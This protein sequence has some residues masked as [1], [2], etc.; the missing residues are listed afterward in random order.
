MSLYEYNG[1]YR[2]HIYTHR[3][4]V[5][6][7]LAGFKGV[8]HCDAA[9]T[10][11]GI[12]EQE[13]VTLSYCHAHGRRKFEEIEKART[14]GKKKVNPGLAATVL[15]EVYRPLYA[16][17]KKMTEQGLSAPD[18]QS[19]R[20]TYSRPILET[21]QSWLIEHEQLTLPHSPIGKAIR[22]AL[23]HW[24]GLVV[25]L[26]DGRVEI[27]NNATERDS[28]P[29]VMWRKNFLFAW[30]QAGADSLGVHFS[31]ILTAKHHGL[32]P[33]QYYEAIFNRLP[34]CRSI[35]DYEA[36]LP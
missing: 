34:L 26:S 8:L 31:L 27:D 4:F 20:D 5:T 29:F 17:E 21:W 9:P 24:A 13:T 36:L 35:E 33:V 30:T 28:K 22:Y 14:K 19:Y 7:N 2:P 12:A 1:Y 15:R 32:N 11:N 3:D 25:F 16:I 23:W 18:K 10:F 6:D